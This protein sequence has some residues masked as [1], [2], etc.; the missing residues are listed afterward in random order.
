MATTKETS[1]DK[2]AEAASLVS[3]LEA[4]LLG[5]VFRPGEWLKQTD[6]ETNYDAHRF[7]VRMALLDL[8]TRQ[9]LEHVPNRGYRVASLSQQDREELIEARTVLEVAAA[10]RVV[11]RATDD[12]VAELDQIV[13]EFDAN[14]EDADLPLLRALNA[15]FHD[16]LYAICGNRVMMEEIKA[17]RHRG[18]PGVR[19]W[20]ANSAIQ[21]SNR[22]HGDMV[23]MIRA[24]DADGLVHAIERHLNRWREE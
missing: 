17:L 11:E 1:R 10:R 5:G 4:D 16:R 14:M 13:A 21:R 6:I 19:G 23:A 20:R 24:R 8:K 18:L 2:E 3:R 9:L 12:D 22:D 15:K 7:D